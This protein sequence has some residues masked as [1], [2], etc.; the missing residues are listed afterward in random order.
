MH[1]PAAPPYN[2]A[3]WSTAPGANYRTSCTNVMTPATSTPRPKTNWQIQKPRPAD[4][5]PTLGPAFA[6]QEWQ[7]S[8]DHRRCNAHFVLRELCHTAITILRNSF[9]LPPRI[10]PP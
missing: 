3:A 7:S 4:E 6:V 9:H 10:L 2:A 5:S 8:I 1:S